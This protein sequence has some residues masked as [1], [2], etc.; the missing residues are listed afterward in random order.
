M[1]KAPPKKIRM[2]KERAKLKRGE[3]QQAYNEHFSESVAHAKQAAK[4]IP[5]Y[6]EIATTNPM[7]NAY[8]MALKDRLKP[9]VIHRIERRKG[10]IRVEATDKFMV[11]KP[12][13]TVF[14]EQKK[15]IEMGDAVRKKGNWWEFPSR[16]KAEGKT[17]RA[18]VWDLADNVTKLIVQ[19][20]SK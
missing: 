14:D 15:I 3:R 2:E 20:N 11:T 8:N 7:W 9:P 10:R 18:Q 17:I 1:S 5:M 19:E 13:V 4:D 6:A 16:S 12:V